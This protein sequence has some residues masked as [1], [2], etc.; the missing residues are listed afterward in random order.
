MSI[1]LVST[2]Y[3]AAIDIKKCT[4]ATFI[5]VFIYVSVVEETSF[6]NRRCMSGDNNSVILAPNRMRF[7]TRPKI[8]VFFSS[9]E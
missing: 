6:H 5:I 3:C 1:F 4:V 2:E 7:L 9:S 8:K